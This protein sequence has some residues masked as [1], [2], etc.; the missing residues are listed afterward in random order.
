MRAEFNPVPENLPLETKNELGKLKKL[1]TEFEAIFL[2]E[3]V[4]AMRKT[5]P[6]S[7]LLDGGNAEEIFKSMQDD[8]MAL[9]MADNGKSGLAQAIYNSLSK[10]YLN[11]VAQGQ[12]EENK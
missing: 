10:P 8:Q 9:Q 4:R 2:Q 1:S 5:V 12:T 6:K 11:A 3:V 7:G